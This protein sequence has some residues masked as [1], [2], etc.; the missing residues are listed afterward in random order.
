MIKPT[1]VVITPT[2][3]R[4]LEIVERCIKSV[5]WQTY[6]IENIIHIIAH[7]GKVSGPSEVLNYIQE[8][9]PIN[10]S[11]IENS[12]NSNS[13]GAGVRQFVLDH[14]ETLTK[15][16]IKYLVHLDD[17][18]LLFPE[19]IQEHVNIL[20]KNK[21]IKFSICKILHMGPLP[22]N[23][24][25]PPKVLTGIPPVFRNIDTLQIMVEIEAMKA[26]GWTQYTG[27]QGYCNDGYTYERLGKM[28]KWIE[29]PKL[30]AIHL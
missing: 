10:V 30:L 17:D 5:Q 25:M 21:D 19:Y 16:E 8:K 2:F 23:L 9:K 26:C 3:N 4:P 15:R 29:L 22:S 13:Y 6:G 1:V 7:D 24:G 18:N 28:F 27:S 12:Q 20:E 14:L 11:Y